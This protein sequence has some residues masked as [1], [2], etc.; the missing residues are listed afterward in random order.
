MQIKEEIKE[1]TLLNSLPLTSTILVKKNTT[2]KLLLERVY[3]Y[4]MII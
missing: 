1:Y 3:I 2:I 4:N